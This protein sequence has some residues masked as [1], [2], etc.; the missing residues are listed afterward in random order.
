MAL[1]QGQSHYLRLECDVQLPG[2]L[3]LARQAKTFTLDITWG[4]DFGCSTRPAKLL[5]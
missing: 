3:D 1:D 2:K 5:F 4:S